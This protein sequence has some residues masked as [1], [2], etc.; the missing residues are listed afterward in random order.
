MNKD[1]SKTNH[2]LVVEDNAVNQIML[3][4]MLQGFNLHVDVAAD[5]EE[6]V[7]MAEEIVPDLIFMDLHMPKM[8]GLEAIRRIRLQQQ[9]KSIPVLV[10]TADVSYE[11]QQKAFLI[12]ATDYLTKPINMRRLESAL[13]R[14]LY[15]G[16]LT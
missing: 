8:D 15:Q 2:V 4:A 9:L 14:Y 11:K 3:R 5:G 6:G 7:R 16:E 1:K 12:G 13:K 10:L